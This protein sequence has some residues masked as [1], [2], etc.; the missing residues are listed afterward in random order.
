VGL[1]PTHGDEKR[2]GP[3]T[4]LDGTV[5]FSFV[6]PSEAEGSAVPPSF[7]GNVFRPSVEADRLCATQLDREAETAKR[8]HRH[9]ALNLILHRSTI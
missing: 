3:A 6:I 2:L 7:L 1:W 9:S 4:T 8:V 5:A